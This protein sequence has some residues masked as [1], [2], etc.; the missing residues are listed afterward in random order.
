MFL[1]HELGYTCVA[2]IR[3]EATMKR[4]GAVVRPAH[5]RLG[6]AI[7]ELEGYGPH[8]RRPGD[9]RS[10]FLIVRPVWLASTTTV[11]LLIVF[12]AFLRIDGALSGETRSLVGRRSCEG[13]RRDIW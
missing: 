4:V 2:R 11:L 12:V 3:R 9:R 1:P 13:R 8:L 5:G 7:G 6:M 10:P